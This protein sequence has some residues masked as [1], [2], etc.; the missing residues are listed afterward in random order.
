M[1][2]QASNMLMLTKVAVSDDLLRKKKGKKLLVWL[3]LVP[4]VLK[5]SYTDG[6]KYW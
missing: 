2:N 3:S 5:N 6:M 1:K 4:F